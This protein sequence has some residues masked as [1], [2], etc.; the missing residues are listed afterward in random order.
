MPLYLYLEKPEFADTWVNGGSV[1]LN[2]ASAYLS[3][4]RSGTKTPDEVRFRAIQGMSDE[5]Y[6]AVS[7]IGPGEIMFENCDLK[8]DDGSSVPLNG[9][10]STGEQDALILCLCRR[11]SKIVRDRLGK[12]VA[13]KISDPHALCAAISKQ[14][15]VEGQFRDVS[16]TRTLQRDH[17]V[18]G[19]TIAGK[20]KLAWSGP[21]QTLRRSGWMFRAGFVS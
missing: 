2:P 13:V 6:T 16:Y 10:F 7:G 17:F 18:K 12:T 20:P 15:G 11:R 8:L 21:R 9:W 1:P 5:H 14:L 3:D 4:T 19:W